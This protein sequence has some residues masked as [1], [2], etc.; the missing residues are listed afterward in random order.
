MFVER[1][2][3]C[4]LSKNGTGVIKKTFTNGAQL[5]VIIE[6]LAERNTSKVITKKIEEVVFINKAQCSDYDGWG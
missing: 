3:Q 1:I 2:V 4:N 5:Y 6:Y